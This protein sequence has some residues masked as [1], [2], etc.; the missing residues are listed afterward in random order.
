MAFLHG[1][2]RRTRYRKMPA[3]LLLLALM[4]TQVLAELQL[5]SHKSCPNVCTCSPN[6]KKVNCINS[7]LQNVPSAD[8]Q[9]RLCQEPWMRAITKNYVKLVDNMRAKDLTKWL[10]QDGVLTLQMHEEIKHEG[11]VHDQNDKLLSFLRGEEAVKCLCKALKQNGNN[12]LATSLEV[13]LM[14][15][16]QSKTPDQV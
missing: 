5:S 6:N 9:D 12:D 8:G 11:I 14:P 13:Q 1:I 3:V 16:T 4:S 2:G 15:K 7:Q 10:I